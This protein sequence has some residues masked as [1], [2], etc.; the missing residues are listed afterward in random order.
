M[1][2][3]GI[4]FVL[5]RVQ[6]CGWSLFS[7]L[8]LPRAPDLTVGLD[9]HEEAGRGPEPESHYRIWLRLGARATRR[10]EGSAS[11]RRGVSSSKVPFAWMP[12]DPSWPVRAPGGM[13]WTLQEACDLFSDVPQLWRQWRLRAVGGHLCCHLE[14]SLLWN[15]TN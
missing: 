4:L 15:E 6:T 13:K 7:F 9:G 12:P 3:I 2:R 1:G 14:P 8:H 10:V 5:S 11:L